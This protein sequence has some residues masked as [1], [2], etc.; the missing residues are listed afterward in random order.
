MQAVARPR[1]AVFLPD[2][3]HA[4]SNRTAV[5]IA[6]GGGYRHVVMDKEGFEMARWLSARGIA[7]FVLFYRLPHQGWSAGPDAALCDA[8]RAMRVLR[9]QHRTLGLI[10]SGLVSW[11]FQLAGMSPPPLRPGLPRQP[12]RRWTAPMPCLR[13]QMQR[14]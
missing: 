8:Q 4:N 11:D 9:S 12:I 7:A 5:L 1:M 3:T 13:G 6:P 10:L 14:R 2:H